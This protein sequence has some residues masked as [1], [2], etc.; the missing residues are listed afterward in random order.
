LFEINWSDAKGKDSLKHHPLYLK[1]CNDTMSTLAGK[2]TLIK[3]DLDAMPF[4]AENVY[5]I[6]FLSWLLRSITLR[7]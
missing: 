3:T 7:A 6:A 1:Y 2:E 5:I 4:R